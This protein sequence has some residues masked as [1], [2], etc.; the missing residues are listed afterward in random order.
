[1]P[2]ALTYPPVSINDS[3]AEK[4]AVTS[5]SS[6]VESELSIKIVPIFAELLLAVGA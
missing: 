4:L 5:I 6:L 1:M 3:P 2:P